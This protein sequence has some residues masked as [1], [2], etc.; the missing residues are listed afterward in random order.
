MNNNFLSMAMNMIEKNPNLLDTPMKKAMF[1]ALQSGD[2]QKGEELA[3]NF[4]ATYGM[5]PQEASQQAQQFV[6]QRFNQKR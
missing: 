2:S 1:Q 4:C 3:R 6:M 5:N